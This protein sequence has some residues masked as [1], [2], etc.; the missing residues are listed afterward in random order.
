MDFVVDWGC[1]DHMVGSGEN[2]LITNFVERTVVLADGMKLTSSDSSLV[3]HK[4]VGYEPPIVYK[5]MLVVQGLNRNL[6]FVRRLFK[7]KVEVTFADNRVLFGVNR[8]GCTHGE[9]KKQLSC[10]ERGNNKSEDKSVC[11]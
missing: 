5:D 3:L 7:S 1:T 6:L 8:K 10:I 9:L 4:K 2:M 11:T